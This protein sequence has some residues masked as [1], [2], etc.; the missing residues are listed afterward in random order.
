MTEKWR[1]V[2]KEEI[3]P[4]DIFL[5][6]IRGT[7]MSNSHRR[8]YPQPLSWQTLPD[9]ATVLVMGELGRAVRLIFR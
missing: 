8:K 6:R 7:Q 5:D 1:E 2:H 3:E 4:A 9:L